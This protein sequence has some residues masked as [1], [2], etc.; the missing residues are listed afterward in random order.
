[1]GIGPVDG[2]LEGVVGDPSFEDEDGRIGGS[3]GAE[4]GVEAMAGEDGEDEQHQKEREEAADAAEEPAEEAG[5]AH[6]T[7]RG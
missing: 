7:F 1:M 2:G 3:V 4:E 6:V 5:G